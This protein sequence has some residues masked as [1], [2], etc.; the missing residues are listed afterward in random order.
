V[1]V[2]VAEAVRRVA[3]GLHLGGVGELRREG[4]KERRRMK[5]LCGE[6]AQ[7]WRRFYRRGERACVARIYASPYSDATAHCAAA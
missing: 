7:Q 3:S 2:P 5:A 4:D 1:E 6:D